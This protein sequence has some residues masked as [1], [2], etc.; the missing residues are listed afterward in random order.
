MEPILGSVSVIPKIMQ[1]LTICRS[2]SKALSRH[3]V[4]PTREH[5]SPI[6]VFMCTHTHVYSVNTTQP[7]SPFKQYLT[8]IAT[9]STV[10][11]RA[12]MLNLGLMRHQHEIG[13]VFMAK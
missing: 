2:G 11:M 1:R 9:V 12:S 10:V 7:N 5:I 3:R 13:A 6:P 8:Q 4:T